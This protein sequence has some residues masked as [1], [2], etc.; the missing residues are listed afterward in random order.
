MAK[1]KT[2][3]IKEQIMEEIMAFKY[4]EV[5]MWNVLYLIFGL[6]L[7]M[8]ARTAWLLIKEKKKERRFIKRVRNME[9]GKP[10]KHF[11][12]RFYW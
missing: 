7:L 6:S 11:N 3:R 8:I 5:W 10:I 9:G 4:F 2:G 1:E 12:G